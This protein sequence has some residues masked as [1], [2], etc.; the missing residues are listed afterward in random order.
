MLRRI[1]AGF[2]EML[3]FGAAG[4]IRRHIRVYNDSMVG[5]ASCSQT[6]GQARRQ[7][8]SEDAILRC[9][10]IV[11]RAMEVDD[12]RVGIKQREG[13]A[14]VAVAWL[15]NRAG[16]DQISR[17]RLQLQW[18]RFG[19]AHAAV[20]WTKAVR[21]RVVDKESALQ[22]RVPKKSQRS[23]QG[24]QWRQRISQRNYIFIFIAGRAVN[25]LYFRKIRQGH[26]AV[27]QGAEPVQ[28]FRCQCIPS[29]DGG[30]S[31][32]WVE[33]VEVQQAGNRLVVIPPYEDFPQVARLGCY[34]ISAS[35]ITKGVSQIHRRIE[36]GSGGEGG[37]QGFEV[38]VDI[39]EQ[40]YSQGAPDKLAI[41]D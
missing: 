6:R 35:P 39:A 2:E 37:F 23:R 18:D 32:H 17:V 8:R 27:R 34:F 19:L 41:I 38:C 40:Q 11:G 15:P 4:R 36:R 12:L 20:F 21:R 31:S 9:F 7:I 25:Q 5:S 13:G 30:R 33:I 16:I 1:L 3:G 22:M 28:I 29:P 10:Q 14:P 26:R 24:D